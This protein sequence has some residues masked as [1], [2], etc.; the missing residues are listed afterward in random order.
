M[1]VKEKKWIRF[2]IH[3]VAVFFMTGLATV[4]ARAYQLQ[5]LEKDYFK[6]I[7][8][9][10]IT[11]VTKLPPERGI[12][13]DR[14]GNELALSIQVGSIFAQSEIDQ[15]QGGNRKAIIRNPEYEKAGY[16]RDFE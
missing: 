2:R 9:N 7:A 10:G 6:D 1:K 5:V 8:D 12:I 4:F 14:E 3:L 15:K 13:Y 11:G 16:P